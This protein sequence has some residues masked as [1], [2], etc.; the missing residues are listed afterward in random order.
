MRFLDWL[1]ARSARTQTQIDDEHALSDRDRAD[2]RG[3]K[4]E[5]SM[6][7]DLP[8]TAPT[9]WTPRDST[10]EEEPSHE[11]TKAAALG[12]PDHAGDDSRFVDWFKSVLGRWRARRKERRIAQADATKSLDEEP[13][14]KNRGHSGPG[15][16]F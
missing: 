7:L 11:A 8:R 5:R 2:I 10:S 15:S 1:Q 6:G 16:S 3:L 14:I 4:D 12:M 9:G 13:V